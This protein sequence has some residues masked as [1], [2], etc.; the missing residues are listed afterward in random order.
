M[1]FILTFE[2]F[3]SEFHA[4]ECLLFERYKEY[5]K[6]IKQCD[7][8][9]PYWVESDGFCVLKLDIMVLQTMK[10]TNTAKTEEGESYRIEETLNALVAFSNFGRRLYQEQLFQYILGTR[11]PLFSFT[12]RRY[13][14]RNVLTN[15]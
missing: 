13:K 8:H 9:L 4:A 10:L 12:N 15:C 5:S 1:N 14:L 7:G 3:D 6:D 11:Q 2:T